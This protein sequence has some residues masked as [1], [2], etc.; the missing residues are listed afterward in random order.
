MKYVMNYLSLVEECRY[1]VVV[2]FSERF[3]M[4]V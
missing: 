4:Y 1:I 3:V 2:A